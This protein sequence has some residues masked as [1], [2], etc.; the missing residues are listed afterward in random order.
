MAEAETQSADDADTDEEEIAWGVQTPTTRI[1]GVPTALIYAGQ[2]G[3]QTEQNDMSYGL[4]LEDV[5]VV[6]GDLWENQAKPDDGLTVDTIDDDQSR[7]TDYRI[8]D[9]DHGRTTIANGALVTDEHGPNTYD[10]AEA[11]GEDSI[12]LWYNGLTGQRLGRTLDFHGRPFARWTDDGE[13]LIKGLLQP[14]TG[15]R[16]NP[17]ERGR[18]AKNGKAPRVARAP[19]LR[20]RVEVSRDDEGDVTDVTL[21]EEPA[22]QR[23][24]IDMS[25][26]EGGQGYRVNLFDAESFEE[27]HGDLSTP[28]DEL[29][30]DEWGNVD[31][32]S[33]LGFNYTPNADD[34]LEQAGYRM[35]MYTGD[36]W[37]DE[38]AAW[39]PQSTSEVDSFGINTGEEGSEEPDG[40][41]A[42]Q[43]QFVREVV[44]EVKGT[45]LTPEEVFGEQGGLEGLIGKY[46]EQFD[47]VPDAD[48]VREAVYE[49]VSH[50]DSDDLDE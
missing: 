18:M 24:L 12:I 28:I 4:V 34:V 47:R 6:T 16:E 31:D 48:D 33:A 8:A 25:N 23:I 9:A 11:V 15:W 10:E 26:E 3:P 50:L 42:Q 49:R 29:P 7:P 39:S 21:L 13:Y 38:P 36:G 2:L 30:T 32:E 40:L 46:Q 1:A 27:E 41:T 5:D 43:E 44:D 22:E 45:G 37:Q 14:A 19:I 17:S 20:Q 35:S